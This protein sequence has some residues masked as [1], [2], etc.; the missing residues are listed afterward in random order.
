M[1]R[2][3]VLHQNVHSYTAQLMINGVETLASV[4]TM[5]ATSK[6]S[7]LKGVEKDSK[8]LF[9]KILSLGHSS[10]IL[11]LSQ[12]SMGL[13]EHSFNKLL[14]VRINSEKG[15][16]SITDAF[17]P[18]KGPKFFNADNALALNHL[19][20]DC[21]RVR[22]L[23]WKEFKPADDQLELISKS[24]VTKNLEATR[25]PYSLTARIGTTSAATMV[26][27]AKGATKFDQIDLTAKYHLNKDL[28]YKALRKE[29][30]LFEEE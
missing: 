28:K 13:R 9:Y 18:Q 12:T 15:G 2:T 26:K 30:K 24:F 3:N 1:K 25:Y 11:E 4:A 19:F 6:K 20:D 7:L 8:T 21:D 17:A 16:F 22:I 14:V 10:L 5:G 23:H 27:L 29:W